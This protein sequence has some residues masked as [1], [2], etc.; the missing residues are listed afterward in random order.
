[1]D[2][3]G[4]TLA[5][6][7]APSETAISEVDAE[8]KR[9]LAGFEETS[10]LQTEDDY[11]KAIEAIRNL[12]ELL[13]RID[14]AVEPSV[15]AAHQAHKAAKALHNELRGPVE[16]AVQFLRG[17]ANAYVNEKARKA[18]EEA[19]RQRRLVEEAARRAA[20]QRA[21]EAAAEAERARQRATEAQELANRV[22][23]A[24][25]ELEEIEAAAFFEQSDI[26]A[27]NGAVVAA[28]KELK[29]AEAAMTPEAR[30]V[31][32]EAEA[33]RRAAEAAEAEAE[34]TPDIPIIATAPTA[35]AVQG[36]SVRT[37][38]RWRVVDIS[39]VPR[40]YMLIDERKI[41]AL[42]K[43]LKAKHGIPGI[44]AFEESVVAVR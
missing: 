16:A 24:R 23:K 22:F 7:P 43:N 41:G 11:G 29:A 3:K 26:A 39:A 5:V 32:E 30:R 34:M 6:V 8:R 35:P 10:Q 38:W 36:A 27:T 37:V 21:A 9:L 42:V 4:K 40:E 28:R 12:N 19:D 44:E 20:E 2:N 14:N 31:I 33:A 18:R 1:M 15:K 13:G 17:L 25:A